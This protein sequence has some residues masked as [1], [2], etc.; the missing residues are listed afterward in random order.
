MSYTVKIDDFSREYWEQNAKEFA[1]YS[2]YQTWPYQQSRAESSGSSVSRAVVT[3]ENGQ[4]CLMCQ[5]RIKHVR[6][7]GLKVGYV[8][9]GPI[10]RGMD[11]QIKCTVSALVELRKAYL[12]NMVNVLRIV[13]NI[14]DDITGSKFCEMLKA[15]GFSYCDTV[16]RYRT[17]KIDISQGEEDIRNKLSANFR[18][19]LVN[20]E[21]SGLEVRRSDDVES[22]DILSR[23]YRSLKQQKGFEGLDI[24]EFA[25]PQQMLAGHEKMNLMLVYNQDRPVS[26]VLSSNLGDTGIVLLAAASPEGRELGGPYLNWYASAKL[27]VQSGKKQFD[28]GGID[29]M[30]NPGVYSFK[31]RMG[32]RE[33]CHI[34][35]YDTCSGSLA[36]TLWVVSDKARS[37]IQ[38]N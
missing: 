19:T 7:L 32:G 9:W 5:V 23:L 18:R 20:T 16:C 13:P 6:V 4:P 25:R 28:L 31:S 29:P 36:K 14:H 38:S 3:D 15:A 8:Q 21:K 22:F 17:F 24:E 11:N 1:D 10:V 12:L 2:L 27:S 35:A 33:V 30:K 26:T 34:G 37:I